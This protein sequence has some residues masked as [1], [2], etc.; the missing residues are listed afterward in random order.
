MA[1]KLWK[2]IT[3][4]PPHIPP[5]STI[6]YG[7]NVVK[8]T[9]DFPPVVQ[10]VDGIKMKEFPGMPEQQTNSKIKMLAQRVSLDKFWEKYQ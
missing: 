8:H 1:S 10:K 7:S 4:K 6:V 5:G 3:K 9:P 2:Y